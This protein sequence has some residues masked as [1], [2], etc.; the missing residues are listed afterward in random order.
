MKNKF[1]L[2]ARDI[3]NQVSKTSEDPYTKV[4]AV[5]LNNEGRI[6]SIGYNG[7]APKKT[8]NSKFWLD[9]DYRRRFMIHAEMNALSCIN[10]YDNPYAIYINV[11]PC[12]YCSNLIVAH[13]I[14][15]VFY[16]EEYPFD[17]NA[18]EIFKFYNIKYTKI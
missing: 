8:V 12:S 11:S 18:K 17:T 16:T 15:E 2:M 4:S 5:V 1:V 6:L 3:A 7:L 10:R 14:K 9:R 13:S